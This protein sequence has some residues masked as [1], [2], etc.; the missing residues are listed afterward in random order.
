MCAVCHQNSIMEGI[1]GKKIKTCNKKKIGTNI[2]QKKTNSLEMHYSMKVA[3]TTG[4]ISALTI[5]I[6]NFSKIPKAPEAFRQ[7]PFMYF[8][9]IMFSSLFV[10][11]LFFM[12]LLLKDVI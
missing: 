10:L 12:V 7:L 1:E 8:S 4:D 9:I 11:S 2:N 5:L 6:I 3:L